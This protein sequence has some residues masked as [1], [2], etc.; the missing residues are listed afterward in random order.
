M[1]VSLILQIY[2]LFLL[3]NVFIRALSNQGESFDGK[4]LYAKF[5]V[6]VL[7]MFLDELSQNFQGLEFGACQFWIS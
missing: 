3:S 7:K 5:K 1:G 2:A 6:G 4:G